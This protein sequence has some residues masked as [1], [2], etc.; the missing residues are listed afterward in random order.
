MPPRPATGTATGTGTDPDPKA[1]TR[2]K[3]SGGSA[4]FRA[5]DPLARL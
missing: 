1:L 2:P 5:N 4:T 3:L